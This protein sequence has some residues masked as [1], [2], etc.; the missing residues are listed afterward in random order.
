MRYM[1]SE[2]DIEEKTKQPY[3]DAPL[4]GAFGALRIQNKNSNFR[5]KDNDNIVE[6]KHEMRQL[7][8]ISASGRLFGP[9]A[10]ESDIDIRAPLL[11]ATKFMI[12]EKSGRA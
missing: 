10:A 9:F 5:R 8:S 11:S 12:A 3:R 7:E 2:V 4:H 1:K 6:N